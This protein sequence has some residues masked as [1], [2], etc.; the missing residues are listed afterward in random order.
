MVSFQELK[1]RVSDFYHFDK[2]EIGGLIASI[3]L[4]AFIFSFR[5]WGSDIFDAVAGFSNL[6]GLAAIIA[7][8]FWLRI[9]FQKIYGLSQGYLVEF[10]TWWMGLFISLI[11]TFVSLGFM[12]VVLIG[13]ITT[14]LM[15][16]QR[17]GEFRYGQS[18]FETSIIA[19]YGIIG[20]ILAA[21][22][23][24][25]GF[26]FMP[27]YFFEKGLLFNLIMAI[28][29]LIPLPQLEGL[30]IFFG[31]RGLYF[32][33]LGLIA[34]ASVLLLTKTAIGLIIAIILAAVITTSIILISSEK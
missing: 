28:C 26:Y 4:M 2:Q 27:N 12:P 21:L 24:A 15:I 22:L 17:L 6:V 29:T 32:I 7:F 3:I 18:H 1:S 20:N 11:I 5:D 14:S 31:S 23:F 25:I 34:L 16:K 10:N 8:S 19:T 30:K 13:G 33:N 9:T